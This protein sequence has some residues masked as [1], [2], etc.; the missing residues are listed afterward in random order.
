MTGKPWQQECE[1]AHSYLGGSGNRD[2]TGSGTWLYISSPA[3]GEPLSP[4]RLY[5]LIHFSTS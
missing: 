5:L 1:A 2:G 4:E 3:W